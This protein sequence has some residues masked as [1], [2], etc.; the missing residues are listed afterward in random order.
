M[1]LMKII[2]KALFVV[3]VLLN[4]ACETSKD[5]EL[6]L[7]ILGERDVEYSMK[8]GK[9]VAD[10]IYHEVPDF[11]YR[12]QD[13]VLVNSKEIK[14]KVWITDFFFTSCPSICPP[15]TSN[16]QALSENVIDLKEHI[17]FLSFSIDPIRDTPEKLRGYIEARDINDDY[18][19]FLNGDE[20]AT[21]LLAKSFFNGA[22]RNSDVDGGFGHTDYFALVDTKGHVRGIYRGTDFE[23]MA[24]LEKDLRQLLKQEYGVD[25]SR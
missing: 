14:G 17:Q 16:M 22:E 7:P 11:E 6:L 2:S 4:F 1:N 5:Q 3:F 25:G 23:Q 15:M 12:T 10:T 20:A 21:H 9:E 19:F 18:W 13:S 8:N 24:V